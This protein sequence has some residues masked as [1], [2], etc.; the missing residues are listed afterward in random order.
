MSKH[1]EPKVRKHIHLYVRDV[2]RIEAIFGGR[3]QIGF[4]KAVRSM[5]RAA[6]NQIEARAEARQKPV[7]ISADTVRAMVEEEQGVGE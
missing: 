5:V 1:D 6:L 7:S 3:D 2:E 4:S